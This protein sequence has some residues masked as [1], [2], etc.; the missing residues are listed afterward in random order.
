MNSEMFLEHTPIE[1]YK[2]GSE[3]VYVKRED[4]Y[5]QAPMPPLAK[6]RGIRIVLDNLYKEGVRTI[7]VLDTRVSKSGQG[8]AAVRKYEHPDMRLMLGFPMTKQQYTN[9]DIPLQ[10]SRAYD[11]GAEL[12]PQQA[13]RQG[14]MYY[15][16]KRAVEE[17]DGVMLPHGLPFAETARS[18]AREASTVPE[19]LLQGSLVLIVGTGTILAGILIGLKVLP[20]KIVG[21]SAGKAPLRQF[22]T[23]NRLMNEIMPFQ[24][25]DT[26]KLKLHFPIMPYDV[27]DRFLCPFPS[28]PNYDRKAWHWM[29]ACIDSLPKPILFWN[30]GA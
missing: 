30:I 15:R 22:Q 24:R 23:I 13:T 4:L 21:I 14:I 7:G 3:T 8:V 25:T 10:H 1:E 20:K 16:F 28:H 19:E 27:A 6:L 29:C 17:R 5:G 26:S 12:Y 9:N 2:V 18:V 11:L